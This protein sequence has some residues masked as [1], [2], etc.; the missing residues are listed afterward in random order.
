MRRI[1][2]IFVVTAA[3]AAALVWLAL[4]MLAGFL[5]RDRLAAY[6]I[7]NAELTIQSLG[8]D[9]ARIV[10][11]K[12]GDSASASSIAVLYS[13]SEFVV[14]RVDIDG[15]VLK[16]R[17]EGVAL[18]FGELDPAIEALAAAEEGSAVPPEVHFKGARLEIT[19]ANLSAT[20]PFNGGVLPK[21]GGFEA[22]LGSTR[23][24]FDIA[25]A[26][27]GFSGAL[28]AVLPAG[29]PL[30]A[31]LRFELTAP[32][33][34]GAHFESGSLYAAVENGAGRAELRLVEADERMNMVLDATLDD[35]G[36]P[37]SHA[38]AR[39][40]VEA[41]ADAALWP[42]LGVPN[43]AEGRLTL[44]GFAEGTM[45]DMAGFI[46]TI[47][48]AA[49]ALAWP[50]LARNIGAAGA[51]DLSFAGDDV[52]LTIPADLLIDATPDMAG[53]PPLLQGPMKM[54]LRPAI[55]RLSRQPSGL[56]L[57]GEDLGMA[58]V[59]GGLAL[60][61][62]LGGTFVLRETS[63]TAT[64]RA[65][66]DLHGRAVAAGAV[67]EG[68]RVKIP[69][70]IEA[71]AEGY[72]LEATAPGRASFRRLSIP[73]LPA[74]ADLDLPIS[75]A[76]LSL[77]PEGMVGDVRIG[78]TDVTTES[79]T[80]Q[81]AKLAVS[82]SE[83][84]GGAFRAEATLTG[85]LGPVEKSWLIPLAFDAKAAIGADA[86]DFSARLLGGAV[87][88]SIEGRHRFSTN[89][90]EARM[91]VA[92]IVFA[93]RGQQPKDVVPLAAN[94][95]E[96]A[97]GKVALAGGGKWKG[98]RIE[99]D[100]KLLLENFSL[101]TAAAEIVRLNGVI[102][103]D[104]LAPLTTPPGQEI[105]IALLDAGLPLTD[106]LVTFRLAP[107]RFDLAGARFA[108]GGGEIGIEPASIALDASV[109]DLA[110][111]AAGIDLAKLVELVDI[112]GLSATGLLDGRAPVRI[113][114]ADWA[115]ED[116][117]LKARSPGR[118]AYAP[119][120][121]PAALAEQGE[122]VALAL[123]ALNDFQYQKLD[124]TIDRAA[125]GDMEIG[126]HLAG[127]NP[128]FYDGYPV[129]FNLNLTGRLDQILRRSLAGYKV[130]DT[131]A[132]RLSQ[133]GAAPR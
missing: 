34:A 108:F 50:G 103:I 129:E 1:A 13:L 63:A 49:D 90:G 107:G 77:S 101:V 75:V 133:F 104:G 15:L 117:R 33:V 86:A 31:T 106:G 102:D 87:S 99:T 42:L 73:G 20:V 68:L 69:I 6:G 88:A 124:L 45:A 64:G 122:T 44:D 38:K 19:G 123:S 93:E 118:I 95:I 39:L 22:I 83:P 72:S 74:L 27:A 11:L 57:A 65:D 80:L 62:K 121:A 16:A 26:G 23:G 76:R 18:S 66:L 81:S 94:W 32:D 79:L 61:A 114:G 109:Y 7:E 37:A 120:S 98:G 113:E 4:P 24:R 71:G 125:G 110:V 119:A 56:V 127:K 17:L 43:P 128:G 82:L 40:A 96:T 52:I 51:F 70:A 55:L 126:V 47:S 112:D 59:S 60:D 29:A 115:I 78:K 9:E 5:L 54:T 3:L 48:F 116:G 132:K 58:I 10:D 2:L 21:D 8:L 36:R 89:A 67:A 25:G 131:I 12:I 92:P 91:T 100:A 41:A 28:H 30:E 53:A 84:A 130:P 85:R 111:A 105:A 46:G 97:S 35:L 14:S